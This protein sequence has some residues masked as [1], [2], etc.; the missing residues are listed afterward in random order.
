MPLAC[1]YFPLTHCATLLTPHQL[2]F[3]ENAQ[4]FGISLLGQFTIVVFLY[5]GYEGPTFFWRLIE[6]VCDLQSIKL[7]L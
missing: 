3:H 5:R 2:H 4:G 1:M 7:L 6:P